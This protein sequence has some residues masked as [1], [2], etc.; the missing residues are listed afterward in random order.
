MNHQYNFSTERLSIN[1][2]EKG[3][4]PILQEELIQSAKN[5]LTPEVLKSL[6]DEW[7]QIHT[8]Q[9][10]IEWIQQQQQESV[11]LTIRLHSNSSI[12]G[13]LFL[14]ETPLS[15]NQQTLQLGYLF[16]E[17]YWGKGLGSELIKGLVEC[18]EK[19]GTIQSITGGVVKDNIGSIKVLEKNGFHIVKNE[20]HS[21][22]LF[23]KRIFY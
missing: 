3:L 23:F 22:T 21:D 17:Q 9:Q 1:H 19:T 5:I 20:N 13:Y 6:P 4:S 18:C 7:Q 16:S 12:I 10:I 11:F 15:N 14:M 8:E 2:L